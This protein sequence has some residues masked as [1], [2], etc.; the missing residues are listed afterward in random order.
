MARQVGK[1]IAWRR[2]GLPEEFIQLLLNMDRE[3]ETAVLTAFG[4]TDEL[5][6]VKEGKF[7]YERGFCQGA[8]ES[9]PGWVALYDI[10]LELQKDIAEGDPIQLGTM[11]GET[12]KY[13]GSVFADDA[14]WV[15][16]SRRGIEVRANVSA[17]FLEFMDIQ[18]NKEKS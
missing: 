16:S 5:I 13:Y 18:F 12:M 11:D 4:F 1:E 14:L 15:S 8:S 17:L 9:P 3:N 6:G 10:F 7:E 2:L